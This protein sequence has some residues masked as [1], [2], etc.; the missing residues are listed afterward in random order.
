MDS[1]G[2]GILELLENCSN[3]EAWL[4]AL[5]VWGSSPITYGGEFYDLR[6]AAVE[7]LRNFIQASS[8]LVH[9][10][11]KSGNEELKKAA[12]S[13]RDVEQ[14]LSEVLS[15]L[16]NRSLSDRRN[17]MLI[18]LKCGHCGSY[19]TVEKYVLEKL[20]NKNLIIE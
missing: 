16:E 20:I 4:K 14:V 3:C 5:E 6:T 7:R 12:G 17:G 13:L 8:K 19:D 1:A 15:A 10:C 2:H 11:E 9:E 18:I